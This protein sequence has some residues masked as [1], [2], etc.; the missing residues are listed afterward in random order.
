[1]NINGKRQME[2]LNKMSFVRMGGT[3]EEMAAAEILME[4]IRSIGMEPVIEEFEIEDAELVAGELE[5]LAPFN[6]KYVVT[7]YKLSESTPEEGLVAPFYYAENLTAVDLANCKGKIVLVNGFFNLDMFKKLQKAGAVAFITMSGI[8][9]LL[10]TLKELEKRN[11]SGKILTTDFI[12]K[13]LK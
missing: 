2:L 5:V 9:P 3:A 1:M 7:A 8:T 6:K 11:V 10:Q 13:M 12:Y 4:E